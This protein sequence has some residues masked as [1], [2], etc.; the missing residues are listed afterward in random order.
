MTLKCRLERRNNGIRI[1]SFVIYIAKFGCITL[2]DKGVEFISYEEIRY[3][4]QREIMKE[5]RNE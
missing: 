3:V 1:N 5:R 4:R 2:R